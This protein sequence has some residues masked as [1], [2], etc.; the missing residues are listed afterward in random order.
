VGGGCSEEVAL[1]RGDFTRL[2][3]CDLD[4]P[5]RV[6]D[7][8]PTQDRNGLG[9]EGVGRAAQQVRQLGVE[10]QVVGRVPGFVQHHLDPVLTRNDIAKDAY[11]ALAIDVETKCVL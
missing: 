2:D 3:L 11:V 10:P 5:S 4:Q 8:T 9:R 7:K 6:S 1:Q